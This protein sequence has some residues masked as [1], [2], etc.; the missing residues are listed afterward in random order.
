MRGIGM[1]P[2]SIGR[3]PN[4]GNAS[5]LG[6]WTWLWVDS[7]SAT[8][9]AS[10]SSPRTPSLCLEGVCV[11]ARGWVSRI[12][13]DMGDGNTVTCRNAGER[14]TRNSNANR[15]PNCG[16]FY[17]RDSGHKA[18]GRYRITATTYWQWT[19][20]GPAGSGGSFNF[21]RTSG[22]NLRVNENQVLIR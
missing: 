12:V 3:T 1:D 14:F 21:T 22:R 4:N 15:R 11:Y 10:P 9:Y 17:E 20:R 18:N 6:L 5:L 8:Q 7:N 2:I 19:W 16:Y 13:Y